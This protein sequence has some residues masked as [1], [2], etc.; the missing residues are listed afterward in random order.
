MTRS[1]ILLFVAVL[2][3]LTLVAG[4][5]PYLWITGGLSCGLFV[6]AV[7]CFDQYNYGLGS[8]LSMLGGILASMWLWTYFTSI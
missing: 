4:G 8:V 3:V 1:N 6:L 7:A 2:G 5:S